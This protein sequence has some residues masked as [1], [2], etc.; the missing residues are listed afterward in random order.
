MHFCN[1]TESQYLINLSLKK[2]LY[3]DL[4][5]MSG[6]PL[7]YQKLLRERRQTTNEVATRI[8]AVSK[9]KPELLSA[10]VANAEPSL[11]RVAL[12]D[13]DPKLLEI[14]LTKSKK[15]LLIVA[16]TGQDLPQ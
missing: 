6:C 14:A 3:L 7:H 8:V 10:A 9:S 2:G 11:L 12:T 5:P 4:Y 16:L 15:E 1:E 13:A